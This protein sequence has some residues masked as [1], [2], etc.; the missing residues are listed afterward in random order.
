MRLLSISDR[1]TYLFLLK[2]IN[3]AIRVNKF[4]S[5]NRNSVESRAFAKSAIEALID[6]GEVDFDDNLILSKEFK[7]NE[8]L[9]C[10][11]DKLAGDNNKLFKETV[12]AFIN[13]PNVNLILTIGDCGLGGSPACTQTD[14]VKETGI[15]TIKIEDID[16]SPIE[17]AQYIIHE[18]IH[19]ELAKYVLERDSTIDKSRLFE[20]YK[21]YR[22]SGVDDFHLDH[23]YMV[24][25]YIGPIA[26]A[27]RQFD[28][29]KFPL[30]YYKSIAW[31]G[32]ESLDVNQVLTKP[33]KNTYK[34]YKQRVIESSKN[35][36]LCN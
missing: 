9:K 28:N 13:N 31:I 15:I 33:L 2:N 26:S 12:G 25:N 17:I 29:N 32:L 35:N 19:A 14:Y 11:Y 30:D 23:P 36:S 21:F 8:K 6:G 22:E 24:L 5:K 20:L 7:N 3:L 34:V 10:V 1:A 27:L 4:I 18:A 16:D